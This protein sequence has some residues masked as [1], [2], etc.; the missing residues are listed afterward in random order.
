MARQEIAPAAPVDPLVRL[1]TQQLASGLWDDPTSSDHEDVRCARATSRALLTLLQAGVSTHHP[2][3]GTQV[4]KAVEALI[5]LVRQLATRAPQV[6][7]L[8]LGVAWLVASG[9]RTRRKIET[10]VAGHPAYNT[11]RSH[12]GNAHTVRLYVEQLAV[13]TG[14]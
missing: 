7:E 6:A 5:T 8:A 3:C 11:L 2:R 1:L 14:Q 13:S 4:R 12:L 10:I 9:Q